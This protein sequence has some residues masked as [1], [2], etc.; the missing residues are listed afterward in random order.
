[1]THCFE[2][3]GITHVMIMAVL[4]VCSCIYLAVCVGYVYASLFFVLGA[5]MAADTL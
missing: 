1:M 2:K 3:Q 5:T 4:S